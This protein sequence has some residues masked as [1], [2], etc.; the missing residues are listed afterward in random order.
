VFLYLPFE[1]AR[2]VNGAERHQNFFALQR[3]LVHD[4]VVAAAHRHIAAALRAT[5]PGAEQGQGRLLRFDFPGYGGKKLKT[6]SWDE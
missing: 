3:P 1:L 6:I 2:L 4:D 5:V